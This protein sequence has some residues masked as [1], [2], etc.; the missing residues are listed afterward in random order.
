MTVGFEVDLDER[1]IQFF[2]NGTR[3][4][5]SLQLPPEQKRLYPHIVFCNHVEVL[6]TIIHTQ[7]SHKTEPLV[8]VDQRSSNTIATVV[9]DDELIAVYRGFEKEAKELLEL[10]CCNYA[11]CLH[12]LDRF[13]GDKQKVINELLG[14][15]M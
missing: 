1:R 3:T 4:G 11:L 12:L 10:G 9:D 2:L 7:E 14:K 13:G 5:N 15:K 8:A 6:V